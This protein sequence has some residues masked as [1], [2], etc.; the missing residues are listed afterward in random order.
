MTKRKEYIFN[1]IKTKK[2]ALENSKEVVKETILVEKQRLMELE[3]ELL[4]LQQEA[5]DQI[6]NLGSLADGLMEVNS[7]SHIGEKVS[8]DAEL[9]MATLDSLTDS[10]RSLLAQKKRQND[11]AMNYAIQRSRLK[12]LSKRQ[13]QE[14]EA[15]NEELLK[16]KQRTFPSFSQVKVKQQG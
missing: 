6:E 11:P 12:E 10:I 2:T 16:M 13:D 4:I 14:I 15:L 9:S 1:M 7:S 8:I 5:K 3:N